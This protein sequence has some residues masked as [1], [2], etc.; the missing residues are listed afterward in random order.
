MIGGL[1][2]HTNARSRS[3]RS[4]NSARAP[5]RSERRPRFRT[6]GPRPA[7]T[8]AGRLL[9]HRAKAHPPHDR[10]PSPRQCPL[11]HRDQPSREWHRLQP[12]VRDPR[13]TTNERIIIARSAALNSSMPSVWSSLPTPWFNPICPAR[14]SP[15]TGSGWRATKPAAWTACAG[16]T[17][18]GARPCA[19]AKCATFRWPICLTCPARPEKRPIWKAWPWPTA[20]LGDGLTWPEAQERQAGPWPRRQRQAAGEG[21]ARRQSASAGLSARRA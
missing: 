14:P 20:F 7:C 19:S 11:L 2:P 13:A 6:E 10:A 21:G 12:A 15:A 9:K 5:A 17:P 18:W 8:N 3:S 4:C 1:K 16:S